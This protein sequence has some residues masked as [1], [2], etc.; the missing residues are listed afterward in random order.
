[1]NI[2][3]KDQRHDKEENEKQ[4]EVTKRMKSNKVIKVVT[5]KRMKNK[6]G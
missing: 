3:E 5:K 6:G 4:E 1:M 2:N